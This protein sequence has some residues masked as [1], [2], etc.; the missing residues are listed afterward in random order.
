MEYKKIKSKL[1][2]QENFELIDEEEI[3][4]D[5]ELF[6]NEL[7][8][9]I[10]NRETSEGCILT[11][12]KELI[13]HNASN[14][15]N[16]QTIFK[17]IKKQD[18]IYY[19]ND[20]LYFSI[21]G[22][23]SNNEILSKD[24][25][26]FFKQVLQNASRQGA[27]DIHL[28][29]EENG[30]RIKFR[31]DGIPQNQGSLISKDLGEQFKNICIVKAKESEYAKNEVAGK[32][33]MLIDQKLK[34]YRLSIAPTAKGKAIVIRQASSIDM[35]SGIENWGYTKKAIEM[36][37]KAVKN[38]F[39]IILV[40]GPTGSGKSTLLY[41]L[42][43]EEKRKN[44]I[45]KT[46]EDPVEIEINGVDQV[47]V[48][49]KGDVESHM[50]FSKAI[51]VFLRQDPDDIVV[52][53]IRDL[54]VAVTAFSAAK[55]G[56]LCLSTLHTNDVESSIS[57]L[58]D[59]GIQSLDLEDSLK[60]IVSQRLVPSLCDNCKI[61][62]I[63]NDGT[64]H[65]KRNPEGCV[66]CESSKIPGYKGRVPIVEIALMDNSRFNYKKENFI[67]YYSLEENILDLLD[68]GKIDKEEANRHI[69]IDNLS[70]LNK[71]KEII[72]IW[73]KIINNNDNEEYL[74]PFYQQIVDK[75]KII[76]GYEIFGR[77]K[78]LKNELYNPGQFIPILKEMN[79]YD[80]ATNHLFNN[81]F[82]NTNNL[83]LNF[84]VNV[85][86]SNLSNKK[87]IQNMLDKIND[88]MTA[89]RSNYILETNFDSKYFIDDIMMAKKNNFLVSLDN[90][91]GSAKAIQEIKKNKI[92]VDFV[93]TYR[94]FIIGF[95]NDE[96][97][98]KPYMEMLY[99][100]NTKIIVTN[101][102]NVEIYEKLKKE[103]GDIIS[104]YQGYFF[105]K[106]L[107]NID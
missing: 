63:E 46:V 18:N 26:D 5:K 86:H 9:P 21:T 39:G 11:N 32:F 48:N 94:D 35:N 52:G 10:Y 85:D 3:K 77:L 95:S 45:I 92:Q 88:T 79:L 15:K 27:S 62:I 40:T 102:E 54:E 31:I 43:V 16:L 56:H 84:F 17:Y 104:Y 97:W 66:I 1:E 67:S 93:K 73:N 4:E 70:T 82:D 65:Y 72:N 96:K 107:K 83:G 44:K 7:F 47:Q 61:K 38:H 81:S 36:I 29:W 23:N 68:L 91:D 89:N 42:I 6:L 64:I 13:K 34:E 2:F 55:T 69:T 53:E 12:N 14:E 60:G 24:A 90:F 22:E 78:N 80:M 87:V 57:R 28:I 74:I 33:K 19:C 71:R 101:I 41:S 106:P 99:E 98:V 76:N 20:E 59:L 100:L 8:Y 58:F 49:V 30:V 50:T 25:E 37:R 103:Y 75:N 51:K 105:G